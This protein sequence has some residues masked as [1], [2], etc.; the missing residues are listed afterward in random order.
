M[1]FGKKQ[2]Q[3]IVKKHIPYMRLQVTNYDNK[4]KYAYIINPFEKHFGAVTI[5]C[6][7]LYA[8]LHDGY[9]QGSSYVES[10]LMDNKSHKIHLTKWLCK[11][12]NINLDKNL[13]NNMTYIA[14]IDNVQPFICDKTDLVNLLTLYSIGKYVYKRYDSNHNDY[15]I[16]SQLYKK[17]VKLCEHA[18]AIPVHQKSNMQAESS[19]PAPSIPEDSDLT[20]TTDTGLGYTINDFD[21]REPKLFMNLNNDNVACILYASMSCLAALL[22]TQGL[23]SNPQTLLLMNQKKVT[24]NLPH[25][26]Q[27]H[28]EIS[29]FLKLRP[30]KLLHATF[31]DTSRNEKKS[32]DKAYYSLSEVVL[33]AN[34]V[35][36]FATIS[37]KYD[38]ED[39]KFINS[40]YNLLKTSEHYLRN[41]TPNIR[42]NT[43][44]Y[45]LPTLRK[46]MT[47]TNTFAVISNSSRGKIAYLNFNLNIGYLIAI[48]FMNYGSIGEDVMKNN[49][50]TTIQLIGDKKYTISLSDKTL[51]KLY[52][53]DLPSVIA[54]LG[55]KLHNS[56]NNILKVTEDDIDAIGEVANL[57]SY[58]FSKFD[59]NHTYLVGELVTIMNNIQDKLTSKASVKTTIKVTQKDIN[60]ASNVFDSRNVDGLHL[61][62]MDVSNKACTKSIINSI[63]FCLKEQKDHSYSALKE[64]KKRIMRDKNSSLTISLNDMRTL[65]TAILDYN[66]DQINDSNYT[67]SSLLNNLQDSIKSALNE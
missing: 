20:S 5:N 26:E 23:P 46:R 31:R 17:V 24:I 8:D 6:F 54:S 40:V 7:L 64:L 47:D 44:N 11:Y 51:N 57:S 49:T 2:L 9:E 45:S 52:N 14:D 48:G 30:I 38:P 4:P 13:L 16:I 58:L 22:N 65:V 66:D 34:V 36:I 59:P 10:T 43:H 56:H 37:E 1:D 27:N 60:Y 29:K 42:E 50:S 67:E 35:A 55:K 15:E 21:I 32:N 62:I 18:D 25:L 53:P 3:D 33:L 28:P 41:Y 19:K 63:S 12:I 61:G 39:M